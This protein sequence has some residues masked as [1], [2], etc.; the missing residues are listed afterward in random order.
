MKNKI[1]MGADMDKHEFK[2]LQA[3]VTKSSELVI[4]IVD[5][6]VKEHCSELDDY[7]LFIKDCLDDYD[8]P[9]TTEELDNFILNIPMLL[10]FTGQSQETLGI[11][12]DVIKS[13]QADAYNNI[14]DITVGTVKDKTAAAELASINESILYIAYARAYK[15]I[16]VRME[17]AGEMLQ[18]VKKV[19]TRRISELEIAKVDPHRQGGANVN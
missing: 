2:G 5:N 1:A 17:Y 18:S 19:I 13:L 14:F 4:E 3:K 9:P 11:K 8:N 7:M 10:Y 6:L 16:K 15:K 12:E